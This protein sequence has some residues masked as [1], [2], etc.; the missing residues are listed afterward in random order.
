MRSDGIIQNKLALAS[1]MSCN[2]LLV[3]AAIHIALHSVCKYLRL[4][5][6]HIAHR[7]KS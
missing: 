4:K 5:L 6:L 2:V 3:L 7:R 1:S